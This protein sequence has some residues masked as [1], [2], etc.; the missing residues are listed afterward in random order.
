MEAFTGF[1]DEIDAFV[2][3]ETLIQ[4]ERREKLIKTSRDVTSL[5]KKVIFHLHRFSVKEGWSPPNPSDSS[6]SKL[7]KEAHDKLEDIYTILRTC[8]EN[9]QLSSSTMRPSSNMLRYERFVGASLEEL[10][11]ITPERFLLG[12]SDLTGE[13]M[14]FA[15]NSVGSPDA[16]KI[17]ARVLFMQRSIYNALEPLAPYNSDIRKKQHVSNTSLRKVEDTA[18]T[19]QVR[20]SE[21][22]DPAMMQEL[23]RR[24]LQSNDVIEP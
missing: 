20:S 1:R 6:N 18:Y 7:L 3:N 2:S 13:L 8:A 14:R 16:S 12:L 5:S 23:V 10:L 21:Y 9:E 15:I 22:S 19:M 4:N 11:Y 17:L 24:A